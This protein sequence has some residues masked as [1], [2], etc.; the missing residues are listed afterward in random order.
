MSR[1]ISRGDIY[2]SQLGDNYGHEQGGVRPVLIIQNNIGNLH[3]P[4]VIVAPITSRIKK[5]TLPTH[6]YISERAKLEKNSVILLE[7]I[8]TIDKSRLKEYLCK[9]Q[10]DEIEAVNKAISVSLG[11]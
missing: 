3:S 9:L 2:Y 7:Q 11:V 8:R 4:T 10:S 6:V 1:Q 5:S